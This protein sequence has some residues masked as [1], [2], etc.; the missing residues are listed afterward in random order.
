MPLEIDRETVK[1]RGK[2]HSTAND[3]RSVTAP[4]KIF[5]SSSSPRER[6]RY[7]KKG[8]RRCFQI[9]SQVEPVLDVMFD[10]CCCHRLFK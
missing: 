4:A 2:P 5:I 7:T 6:A 9:S 10:G 8:R 1:L 3:R